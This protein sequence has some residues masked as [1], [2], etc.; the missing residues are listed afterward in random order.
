MPE[1]T[2]DGIEIRYQDEGSGPVLLLVHGFP[3]THAMWVEQIAALSETHRVIA[4]DLQG[5]GGSPFVEGEIGMETY[6]ADLLALL[7]HLG[8]D[9]PVAMAGFSMGGYVLLA[10]LRE[11]AARVGRLALIDTKAT[12][13][14]PEAEAGRY[15]AADSVLEDGSG[16]IARAMIDKLLAPAT[17]EARPDLEAGLLEMMGG[18]APG[19]VA[20][21]LVA[22]AR[23]HDST[24]MLPHLDIPTLVV[25]GVE[26]VIA[27]PSEARLMAGEIPG[28]Q[29]VEISGAGH[30][31]PM[32]QPAAVSRA[33]ASW[34]ADA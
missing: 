10:L 31:A 14:S 32:E 11:Q 9:E 21:A 26:D 34:L 5:F 29:L 20:Q 13:D 16:V 1:V 8:L 33:L 4:P 27:T 6:A 24:P 25:V 3:L 28:A 30:M 18:Q 23:R 15:T 7:D 12:A 19:A 2:L 17:R 22:M